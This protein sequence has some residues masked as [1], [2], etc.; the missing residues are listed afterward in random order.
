MRSL[1][2]TKDTKEE[3][4]AAALDWLCLNLSEVILFFCCPMWPV[5]MLAH[6]QLVDG[7]PLQFCGL[8]LLSACVCVCVEEH[9]MQR[10]CPLFVHFI[11]DVEVT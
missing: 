2:A 11:P 6:L 3:P 5:C 4:L 7:P 8:K 1:A 10:T 9:C